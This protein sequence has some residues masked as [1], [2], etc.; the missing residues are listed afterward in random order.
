MA[1]PK[2]TR[3]TSA[4]RLAI[5]TVLAGVALAACG[6]DEIPQNSLDPAG[7]IAR[8]IDNLWWLVFWIAAVVFVLVQAALLWSIFRFRAR[9]G[10]EDRRIRQLHGNTKLEVAW[11]IAPA[12]LLAVIA[13]PTVA[14]LFDITEE[15]T[16]DDVLEINVV[17]HQWWWE[18]EYPEFGFFTANEMHIPAGRPVYLTMTSDDVI[19]SFWLPRLNGKRDL[20]PGRISHLT[21][22]ADEPTPDGE[23][24]WGQCA[25]FCGLSHA[26]MRL[27]VKVHDE[28]GFQEWAA[29]QAQPAVIPTEGLA[30]E[31]WEIFKVVC[32]ACH[33]VAGAEEAN[34]QLAPDLTH[35]ASRDWFAGATFLN[36][37]EHLRAWL[38]NPADLKP[39]APELND[40]GADPPRILGMPNFGLDEREVDALIALL[41]GWE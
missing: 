19:H 30:A 33:P 1:V 9:K 21:L 38:R 7:P 17:G 3:R 35:Y 40:L 15:P 12:V 23:F 24:L 31:G 36:T 22:F 20:V 26:D 11:T 25:E 8:D 41:Q 16:G 13:V 29:G 14:T 39:M 4:R 18:Y 2:R 32:T 6:D 5:L 28:E 37:T 10:D 27:K 34:I